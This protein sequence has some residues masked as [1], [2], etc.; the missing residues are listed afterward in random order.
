MFVIL[1]KF[2]GN[3]ARARHLMA[4]HKAWLDRGF[5]DG[6]FL[7]AGSLEP[8]AG[9]AIAA[10]NTSASDLRRRVDEDPFVA[11]QVVTAEILE[12]AA[13]RAEPRLEFLLERSS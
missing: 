11:E 4:G 2:T 7:L 1:L 8:D 3:K 10:H 12:I 13:S 6:V 9:G 5:A